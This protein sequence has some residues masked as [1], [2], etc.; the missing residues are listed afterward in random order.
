MRKEYSAEPY[1]DTGSDDGNDKI[2]YRS[3]RGHSNQAEHQAADKTAN[4]SKKDVLDPRCVLMHDSGC[5]K[6][7]DRSKYQAINPAIA[8]SIRLHISPIF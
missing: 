7:G 1:A 6:P 5:D 3:V 2:R 4:D 8:P